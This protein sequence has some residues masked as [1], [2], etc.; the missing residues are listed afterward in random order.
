MQ[1]KLTRNNLEI[2]DYF[3]ISLDIFLKNIQVFLLFLV[4]NYLPIILFVAWSA[5]I[6]ALLQNVDF[7]SEEYTIFYLFSAVFIFAATLV[8]LAIPILTERAVLGRSIDA[9]S[10]LKTALPKVIP[11]LLVTIVFGIILAVGYILLIVPG[12][13]LTLSFIFFPQVIALRKCRVSAL[14]Y[15][16]S[17]VKGQ[18]WKVFS[19]LFILDITWCIFV[20]LVSILF[21]FINFIF[22]VSFAF[23]ALQFALGIIFYIFGA[24]ISCLM[25]VIYVVFFLNLDYIK[26]T[27]TATS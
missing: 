11:M 1:K 4:V 10:I 2:G 18:W 23:P 16:W 15:S 3:D 20:L 14:S 9:L 12:I 22:F 24:S 7:T 21:N 5:Q 17:L 25:N 27:T 19:R 13:Y 26:N 6:K 8:Q